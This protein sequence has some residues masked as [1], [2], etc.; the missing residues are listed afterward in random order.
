MLNLNQVANAFDSGRLHLFLLP[1]EACNFRCVY[2]YEDFALGVMPPTVRSGIKGL[3]TARFPELH[4]IE[5]S[6]FG[7]EPLLAKP[8]IED[9]SRHI[10]ALANF[11]SIHYLANITTNGYLLNIETAAHLEQLGITFYQIALDGPPDVHD[12]TRIR[13]DGGG[14]FARIW[15]NLLAI[16]DSPLKLSL[17]LRVHFSPV[18][19]K[20]LD[21]LI[22]AINQEFSGDDRFQV[23]FKAVERLGGANNALI[24]IFPGEEKRDIANALMKK[25]APSIREYRIAQAGETYVCYAAKPNSLVIRAN[26][27]IAKC[28]VAFSDDRNR[29]G[30]LSSDGKIDVNQEKM[31]WWIRGFS[32]LRSDELTCPNGA[33]LKEGAAAQS[34]VS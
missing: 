10:Q 8:V 27:D 20:R 30:V 33:P 16:R 17:I 23:F 4:T 11:K 24:Q 32:S 2:C 9:I 26:G 34:G 31:R 13:G 15:T 12:T 21:P 19:Y 3:I 22:D 6:W 5:V 18:N 29:L 28:T 25:L 1:T 14:T 7:G